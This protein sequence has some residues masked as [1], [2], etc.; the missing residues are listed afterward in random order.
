MTP[1]QQET[2]GFIKSAGPEFWHLACYL[3]HTSTT[4]GDAAS[5][6]NGVFKEL[7]QR[8]KALS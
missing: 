8:A 3:A 7:L 4:R 2:S 6:G 1:I 5:I